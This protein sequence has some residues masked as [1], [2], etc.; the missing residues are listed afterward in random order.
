MYEL[1]IYF[2]IFSF[3]GWCSEVCFAAYKHGKFVNRG[4]LNGPVCPIYGFG[5]AG[6]WFITG[7][8]SNDA[9]L[10]LTCFLLPSVLE[11]VTGFVLEKAF[12]NKW[13]DYS[14]ERWNV[15]GYICAKFSLIWGLVCIAAVKIIFPLIDSLISVLPKTATIVVVCVLLA[16]MLVDFI[17][18]I[19]VVVKMNTRLK[20]I[21]A[22]N[23][24]IHSASDKIGQGVADGALALIKAKDKLKSDVS[25]FTKR[26]ISAFPEMKSKKY[27]SLN[28]LRESIK[29]KK[30]KKSEIPVSDDEKTDEPESEKIAG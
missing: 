1:A 23:E 22:L 27:L 5:V 17:G 6:V 9:V 16:V 2:L 14:K 12:H 7:L 24:K 18:T 28:E 11:L 10:V 19:F 30:K 26:L 8:I 3:L 13:W 15:G 29:N 4:F 20:A 21:D 25:V